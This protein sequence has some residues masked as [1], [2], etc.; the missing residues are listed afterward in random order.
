MHAASKAPV[1]QST[2][3]AELSARL[4]QSTRELPDVTPAGKVHL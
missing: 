1:Q 2:R 4:S 3:G